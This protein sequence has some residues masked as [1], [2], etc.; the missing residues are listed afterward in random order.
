[1]KKKPPP[2]NFVR[3]FEASARHLS[4]TG[5]AGE[6]GCTQAAISMHIRSLE[7]LLGV[8][9]FI[10]HARSLA[11]TEAGAA[12]L[13]TLRQALMMIDTATQT[14][15]INTEHRTVRIAAPISL[16]E[17]WLA[18]RLAAYQQRQPECQFIVHGTVWEKETSNSDIVIYMG[19]IIENRGVMALFEHSGLSVLCAPQMAASIKSPADI[20]PA[21][22]IVVAGRQEY[23]TETAAHLNLPIEGMN[24]SGSIRVDASNIAL[25]LAAHGAGLVAMP[26]ETGETYINRGLLVEPLGVRPPCPWGYFIKPLPEKAS[27]EVCKVVDYLRSA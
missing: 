14:V 21:A 13:P 23:W 4:F 26:L 1:M 8:D 5:A 6:L 15:Q 18:P 19:R 12:Y 9:L 11:L 10:R 22:K 27:H 24:L 25:E 2:L 17:N 16:A 3:S 7:R 20:A